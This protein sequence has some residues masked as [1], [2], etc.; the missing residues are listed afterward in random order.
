[1]GLWL[2]LSSANQFSCVCAH[3]NLVCAPVQ[4][5]VEHADHCSP[6]NEEGNLREGRKLGSGKGGLAK[7]L[8]VLRTLNSQGR[9]HD[10]QKREL[11]VLENQLH[12]RKIMDNFVQRDGQRCI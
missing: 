2:W 1:V 9:L 7:K 8:K 6:Y 10:K 4:V 3:A 12:Q 11:E 5:R